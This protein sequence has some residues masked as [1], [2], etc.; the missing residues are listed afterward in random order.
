[1]SGQTIFKG[2]A[3]SET[4]V[5]K[6]TSRMQ[7]A[8]KIRTANLEK[9]KSEPDTNEEKSSKIKKCEAEIAILKTKTGA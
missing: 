5:N 3:M 9:W 6:K 2:E 8:L 1:M 4:K 7:S